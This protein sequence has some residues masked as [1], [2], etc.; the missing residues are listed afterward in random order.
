M[1]KLLN[2]FRKESIQISNKE[3]WFQRIKD[4]IQQRF[5]NREQMHKKNRFSFLKRQQQER[6][7]QPD[8]KVEKRMTLKVK[9]IVFFILFSVIPSVVVGNFVYYISKET[10]FDKTA[11]MSEEIAGQVTYS[12]DTVIAEAEKVTMLPFSNSDLMDTLSEEY[13]DQFEQMRAQSDVSTYFSSLIFSYNHFNNFFF[14]TNDGTVMGS[15]NSEFDTNAFIEN[16]LERL[17]EQA[18]NRAVWLTG[19]QDHY[20]H[21]YVLRR[22]TGSFGND[23]GFLVL[24]VN[25]SAFSGIF[26]QFD[27]SSGQ[28]I[29]VIDSEGQIVSSNE[30]ELVGENFE[31]S[32]ET[33]GQL[34]SENEGSTGWTISVTTPEEFL[35]REMNS[36]Y[37]LVYVVI[38]IFALIS[39]VVGFFLTLTITKPLNQLM[40][41]MKVAE[42]GDLK[43]KSKYLYSNEIGQLGRSF[44]KM[45]ANFKAI[46]YENKKVSKSAVDSAENLNKI[47]SE[48]SET[49]EQVA[50]AIEE[51]AKGAVEQVNYSENTNKEMNVLSDEIEGVTKYVQNVSNATVKTQELSRGSLQSMQGLTDKNSAVG[52]NIKSVESTIVKLSGDVAEIRQ[53]IELIRNISDQTNLL[54]LNASIE[55]ARAG[56]SAGQGF[57]VVAAE[58]RKLAEKSKQSTIQIENVISNI[59][60]VTDE[61]V[62]L[63]NQ[64]IVL[65]DEQTSAIGETRE[66]FNKIIEDTGSIITEIQDI[67]Q[68]IHKINGTKD[69]VGQ[70]I[71]EMVKVAE[72]SS[73]TTEEVTATTEEQAAAAIQLGHLAQD[74]AETMSDLEEQINKF[75]L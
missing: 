8:G 38:G 36:V 40:N 26:D 7:N 24:S 15:R 39:I 10:I 16:D 47:S 3:S 29:Y 32:V 44:N 57:A 25:R 50:A 4:K 60:G 33:D 43:V 66:S 28:N 20:G 67:E 18:S 55:A 63:V 65:F 2:R 71:E 23:L 35:L 12:V 68:S 62:D 5:S 56:G 6:T 51:L 34:V 53:I 41:L 13:E 70:A 9:L 31:S 58:I 75:K 59:L 19:Y 17:S 72:V 64:S 74:L 37:Y 14:V 73:S 46:I 45:V 27:A 61:S 11:T 21:M 54:S 22:L 48:S 42:N 30:R 49:A 1:R 69:R 52:E